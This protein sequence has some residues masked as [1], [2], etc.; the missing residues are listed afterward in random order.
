MQEKKETFSAQL[1]CGC[2]MDYGFTKQLPDQQM[3][4]PCCQSRATKNYAKVTQ[5]LENK[6]DLKNDFG[7]IGDKKTM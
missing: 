5:G 1:A 3:N 7:G 2:E 6:T 4:T